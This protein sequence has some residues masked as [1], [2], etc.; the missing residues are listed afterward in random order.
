MVSFENI[1]LLSADTGDGSCNKNEDERAKPLKK[2]R[3]KSSASR[4][5][6]TFGN[7][8]RHV[9]AFYRTSKCV[10]GVQVHTRANSAQSE[11]LKIAIEWQCS[12]SATFQLSVVVFLW[13]IAMQHYGSTKVQNMHNGDNMSSSKMHLQKGAFS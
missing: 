12:R 8:R 7:G 4:Y 1:S 10:S 2:Y 5:R 3:R 11:M 13:K 6:E 9:V